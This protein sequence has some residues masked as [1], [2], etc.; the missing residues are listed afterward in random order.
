MRWSHTGTRSRIRV[1]ALCFEKEPRPRRVSRRNSRYE[2]PRTVSEEI[3]QKTPVIV[4]DGNAQGTRPAVLRPA[5][6][7]E[8][9]DPDFIR[10]KGDHS[11]CLVLFPS[12]RS[13]RQCSMY[14]SRPAQ[15]WTSLAEKDH[16]FPRF[17]NVG[18]A[19]QPLPGPGRLSLKH[20]GPFFPLFGHSCSFPP[21]PSP[22]F[23]F[24]FYLFASKLAVRMLAE[25]SFGGQT[26]H[27]LQ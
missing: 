27:L 20:V 23:F 7:Q 15:A 18:G 22:I 11:S 17:G 5:R 14:K 25:F 26:R 1:V 10:A 24:F 9:T 19:P 21:P 2:R 12:I 13:Y 8:A 4:I 16:R 6:K 3:P